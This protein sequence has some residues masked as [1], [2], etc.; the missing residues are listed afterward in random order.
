MMGTRLKFLL[1]YYPHMDDQT[2]VVNRSS[3]NLLRC[4]VGN[5]VKSRDSMLFIVEFAYNS[6]VNK[7]IDMISFEV[8]HKYKPRKSID[9]I[10]M[11]ISQRSSESVNAFARHIHELHSEIKK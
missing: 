10:P 1:A 2:E 8:V 9:L 7:T 3:G 5:H 11:S 6:F 4:L